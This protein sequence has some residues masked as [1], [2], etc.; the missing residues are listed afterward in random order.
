MADRVEREIEEILAKLDSELPPETEKKPIPILSRKRAKRSQPP[1]PPRPSGRN[2]SSVTPTSM[3]FTGAGM[4]VGGLVLANVMAPLI[5]ISFA[6][7]V[8]F[9]GAFLSSFFR[10]APT[11]AARPK[12]VYWRDRYI[13]YEPASPG[14]FDRIKRAFRR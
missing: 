6:G 8:L 11:Q 14:L 12:G 4:V 2:R 10:R 13:E 1:K 7:V 5:W 9:L 3:M